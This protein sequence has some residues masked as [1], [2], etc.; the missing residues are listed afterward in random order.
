MKQLRIILLCLFSFISGYS[1]ITNA[2]Y[3][4][5][6]DPGVGN[7]TPLTM[8]GSTIDQ[9]YSIPTTGLSEG[10]HRLYV[11]VQDAVGTWSVYDKNVF[12]IRPDQTNS[13]NIA[14][15]EYF[16]DT[17]P[18]VGNGTPLTMSGSVID[19]N[20]S[21]P[22]TGLSDGIHKLYVRIINDNGTWSIYDKNVFYIN[23]SQSNTANIA[24]AEYFF[25]TDPG[26][27][28]GTAL[29][30]TGSTVDQN[31]SIPT[32]GLSDG[33]H[34]LYVR[35]IND[36]GSWSI[37]D[38]NVF[39]IN[40][41][42]T[43][44]ANIASAEY[45]FDTDPGIGNGTAL[46]MSGS[47]IDQ[48]YNI[49]TTGLSVGVHRLY[50][51][52]INDDG[53]W[54]LYDRN[55]FYINPNASNPALI[56]SAEYF[57]DTDLGVGNGTPISVSGSSIDQN[58][59]VPTTGLA[60]G[61]YTLYIRLINANGTWSL[62]DGKPFTLGP[63][64]TDG[65]GIID[66]DDN[67]PLTANPGQEDVDIDTVGDV[68]DNCPD[69]PNADQA[70]SDSDGVGDLCD[71]CPGFDDKVDADG[72]GFP[73]GC[74]CNDND[75][76]INPDATEVCDGVDNNC[77]GLVDDD[78]P[79]VTG[80]STWY[81][82]TDGDGF[83]DPNVS[84]LACGQPANYVADN[85]DCNDNE[86]NAY[87]GNPEVCDGIDNNCDGQIDEGVTTTYY[88]DK[89]GDGYGDPS[90]TVQACS[91]PSGYVTDNTDCNDNE[92]NAFPG[93]PEVCD[94][95]DN[96][97]DGQIDESVTNT[98][99]ADKDG[100]GYGDPSDTVQACSPP[101]GYVTDNTDCN[102]NE[103]NAFPGNPEVCDGIDNNCDGQIDEGVTNTYYADNDGDGY[104]NPDDTIM[105]CSAPA[106]YVEDNTDCDDNEPNNYP[107]NTEVCDGIDNDCDGLVDD[108]DDSLTGAPT[109]YA[110]A[111]GDG[112][113]NP[114]DSVTSCNPPS[115]YIADG[116][117]C[118]DSDPNVHPG[119]D[120]IPNDGIDQDCN[121]SDLVIG[122]ADGDG[123]LDNVD[124][125]IDTPNPDQTDSDNDGIGDVCDINGIVV[126]NG[127]S[128][129][130]TASTTLGQSRTLLPTP[131]ITSRCSTV[132]ET[133]CSRPTITRIIGTENRGTD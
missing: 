22:T 129:N 77:N 130:G 131:E 109:W 40:P 15:A 37:Y 24:S 125:C 59:A 21:I 108:E 88:A 25:D 7:G 16:I 6:T 35:T 80:Q 96:N 75:P 84:V 121:G 112:Y 94:G 113:G 76:N 116:S 45:F 67:C 81:A 90:D 64:D 10:I 120:E 133:R 44:T 56:T 33:I 49:P 61:T 99:Y 103:P 4:F 95:I 128:P 29:A 18:G 72:D 105:A 23:P 132:G 34:K 11:R 111:D 27:G 100:D 30:M 66:T 73:E 41:S 14:A 119:A 124:N 51:R 52:V 106:G 104:G 71:I 53:T 60:D 101:S 5:D 50:I 12:Y 114:S 126:P 8:S 78:D 42:Q 65:D 74:D 91:V 102:D 32:T 13:A 79:G 38:K 17:D 47:S 19:Q 98:Y 28:N 2:E 63:A 55:A 20:Y 69:I 48:N 82:D 118:D 31:Y 62:Y 9:N 97:C 115:G 58:I 43:N 54:S 87:P 110:D 39:Y 92:P 1:Q 68:C 117:D 85:T 89:D 57:L 93:N 26:V 86:P 3:F 122:D 70:D 107:G 46:T 123:V 36:D 83:G 127:F